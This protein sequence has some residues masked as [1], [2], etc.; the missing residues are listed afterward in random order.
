MHNS[1]LCFSFIYAFTSI[2]KN[3]TTKF[4]LEGRGQCFNL[5]EIS[6]KKHMLFMRFTPNGLQCVHIYSSHSNGKNQ[7]SWVTCFSGNLCHRILRSPIRHYHDNSGHILLQRSSS[8]W[9][10]K[11]NVHCI[12][13]GQASHGASCQVHH[14]LHCSCDVLLPPERLQWKLVFDCAAELNQT[15]TSG[16]RTDIQELQDG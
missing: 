6:H 9:F 10:W 12:L 3:L 15:Y 14:P 4:S 2:D 16:I 1:F 5:T 7:D 11:C 8:F 13:N